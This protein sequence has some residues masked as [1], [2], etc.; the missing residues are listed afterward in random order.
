MTT[1]YHCFMLLYL[2]V[3]NT[4]SQTRNQQICIPK[5]TTN[6]TA[7]PL[8]S[9]WHRALIIL[10]VFFI[11]TATGKHLH[12]RSTTSTTAACT[13]PA[14]C[15]T[16]QELLQHSSHYFLSHT[17]ITF[18]SGYH[19]V[20][21]NH[22][23]LVRNVRNITLLGDV[24]DHSVIQ[25]TGTFGL[26]FV[27][28]IN[29]TISNLNFY[30]CGAPIPMQYKPIGNAALFLLDTKYIVTLYLIQVSSVKI[31]NIQLTNSTGV[32]MLGFNAFVSISQSTFTSNMLNCIFVFSKN[33]TF[34]TTQS[35]KLII[36]SSIFK[37]GSP[38]RFLINAAGLSMVF[39]QT[40]YTVTVTI[41]N[42][43][44]YNNKTD[45]IMFTLDRCSYQCT[46]V[47]AHCV[48]S[49]GASPV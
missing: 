7:C 23:A 20:N 27:N 29:L 47:R 1:E 4:Y 24:H 9:G 6:M 34:P 3:N 10:V 45:N 11:A 16:L 41:S 15:H 17:I 38:P 37:L 12:V 48:N 49:T 30:L 21:Y 25:C 33:P 2:L 46:S 26:S 31:S 39:T 5:T 36:T 13:Q 32:G 35:E 18:Q 28:V 40:T 44:T 42:V 43:T 14:S 19:E 8:T 22:N